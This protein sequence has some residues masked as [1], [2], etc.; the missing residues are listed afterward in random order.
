MS[1]VE[2][3]GRKVKKINTERH[4]TKR[5]SGY[6]FEITTIHTVYW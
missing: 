1:V 2:L 3:F 4:F 6:Y 5:I